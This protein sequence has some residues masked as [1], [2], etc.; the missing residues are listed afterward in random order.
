MG[1]NIHSDDILI[2]LRKPGET[3]YKIPQVRCR[4]VLH[5]GATRVTCPGALPA[6][7]TI[8]GRHV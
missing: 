3:G 5:R 7:R 6:S 4:C 2:N 8:A 1:I